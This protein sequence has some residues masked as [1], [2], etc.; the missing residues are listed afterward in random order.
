MINEDPNFNFDQPEN[1]L[2]TSVYDYVSWGYYDQSGF[3]S[4]PVNWTGV[5]PPQPPVQAVPI[6]RTRTGGSCH[7]ECTLIPTIGFDR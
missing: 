3:Q 4:P 6:F 2:L 5:R 7:R 1:N